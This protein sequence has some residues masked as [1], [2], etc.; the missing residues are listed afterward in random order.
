MPPRHIQRMKKDVASRMNRRWVSIGAAVIMLAVYAFPA[1]AAEQRSY[2]PEAVQSNAEQTQ[3]LNK[4]EQNIQDKLHKGKMTKEDFEAYRLGKLKEMAVYFGI[5]AE[6]KSADQLKQELDAAKLANKEKWEVYKAEQKAKRLEH[7]RK[8]AA[9]HG[10]ETDG[11]SAS[12]LHEEIHK[13]HG[14]KARQPKGEDSL[15]RK[16]EKQ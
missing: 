7:L 1:L 11:K 2:G 16:T 10:I 12:Q 6:G 8:H 15:K 14:E 3:E 4:L 5:K 9:E 13:I